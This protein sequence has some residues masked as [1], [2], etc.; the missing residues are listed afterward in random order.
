MRILTERVA[1]IETNRT[2]SP[3]IIGRDVSVSETTAQIRKMA[4]KYFQMGS[5]LDSTKKA[6]LSVVNAPEDIVGII[7]T[8]VFALLEAE[9]MAEKERL[10]R[11]ERMVRDSP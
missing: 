11:K 8:E 5:T 9:R 1:G 6:I 7:A 4:A 10:S 2:P 3:Y